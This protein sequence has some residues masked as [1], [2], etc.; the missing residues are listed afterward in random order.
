MQRLMTVVT[1]L[2][3]LLSLEPW[4]AVTIAQTRPYLDSKVFPR[5][6]QV[7]MRLDQ[8]YLTVTADQ[9]PG[10]KK[11]DS[12]WKK[13]RDTFKTSD[14]KVVVTAKTDIERG[15]TAI[16]QAAKVLF[17]FD[18][19]DGK[20]ES[21]VEQGS[22]IL[23]AT[24]LAPTD[25]LV[26]RIGF[27][28]TTSERASALIEIMNKIEKIPAVNAYTVGALSVTTSVI[29]VLTSVIGKPEDQ[30]WRLSKTFPDAAETYRTE[31]LMVFA[32]DDRPALETFEPRKPSD[33]R[34]SSLPSLVL[35]K[36]SWRDS[37]ISRD[38][39]LVAGEQFQAKLQPLVDRIRDA[40]G[41]EKDRV[42]AE[43]V[44][45]CVELRRF[46]QTQLNLNEKDE[47]NIALAAMKA[48]GYDPDRSSQHQDGCFEQGDLDAARREGFRIGSC[49]S[50]TCLQAQKFLYRWLKKETLQQVTTDSIVWAD[51]RKARVEEGQG[52][53]GAFAKTCELLRS[54]YGS[55]KP[56]PDGAVSFQGKVKCRG[57][58]D[59]SDAKIVLSYSEDKP[60]KVVRIDVMKPEG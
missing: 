20:I 40:R 54:G 1:V 21:T 29:D 18:P 57:E 43:Q 60:D 3:S 8:W 58:K 55:Y 24:R 41:L 49:T 17:V 31:Y 34:N 19:K 13:I 11:D 59:Y 44:K 5:A 37:V 10:V 48:G 26:A 9:W 42:A 27:S 25:R 32:A 53:A 4:A 12:L 52:D 36:L 23:P 30:N 14:T 7:P 28:E 22:V 2:L 50:Q 16:G 45:Q 6:E 46:V 51:Q 35:L 47:I 39:V 15:D 33:G 56:E 38:T